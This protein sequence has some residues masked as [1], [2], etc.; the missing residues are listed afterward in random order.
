[1][2]HTLAALAALLLAAA[3]LL[4][5]N[6]LQGSLLAVRANGEG[7]EL[8]EIGLMMSA[9]FAGYVAGCRLIPAMVKDVGHIRTFTAMASI[10]SAA[11]LAHVLLIDATVWMVLRGI[12][13]FCF[14]GLAMVIE[15]W[16]NEKATN[17]NRGRV[18]SIYRMVDLGSVTIGQLLLTLADPGAF[19]LF[20]IVSILISMSLVPVALST[21]PTPRPL[22]SVN[23]DLRRVYRI[24]PQAAV[25]SVL[26]GL[27]SSGFWALG[28]VFAQNLGND[29]KLIA[30]YMG[31]T[32]VSAAAAQWP[33]GAISDR[34]DRRV[35]VLVVTV[36]AAGAGALLWTMADESPGWMLFGGA[37]FGAFAISLFGMLLTQANDYA[38]PTEYVALNAGL[39]LL[40]GLGSIVG[41]LL[42]S[43]S[44]Q[45]FGTTALYAY[46]M[47]VHVL[48]AMFSAWRLTRR[49]TAAPQ[50][51]E[52]F[53]PTP[54]TSPMVF[55]MDPRC[56]D[57]IRPPAESDTA[58]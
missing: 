28:P 58:G 49:P 9:Y 2:R 20:A 30:A 50:E 19:A 26:T 56:P 44:M 6:G 24:S 32:I 1:M 27:A 57:V 53:I 17:A 31:V 41:P 25:G 21:A 16:I 12:T 3:V 55:E 18:L 35:L 46:T 11:A 42:A 54:A 52:E 39:L 14:A 43:Q 22:Q 48:L 13:G 10:A 47:G 45:L 7:F 51:R 5:G 36:A 29:T 33:L 40:Y 38:Q 15:S 8:I 37:L 4:T 23:L 34:S